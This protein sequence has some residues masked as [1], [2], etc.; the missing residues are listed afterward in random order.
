MNETT[1]ENFKIEIIGTKEYGATESVLQIA[2]K[3]KI[4]KILSSKN[5]PWRQDALALVMGGLIYPGSGEYLINL[6]KDSLLWQHCGHAKDTKPDYF[7]NYQT[8]L[9]KIAENQWI[10]EAA[11][12]KKNLKTP[13]IIFNICRIPLKK[14]SSHDNCIT[15]GLFT[16]L[17]GFP[18]SIK[19]FLEND[20][21][22]ANQGLWKNSQKNIH[23]AQ[24]K[25][26][27]VG[28]DFLLKKDFVQFDFANPISHSTSILD[29]FSDRWQAGC[30]H[31]LS[32]NQASL[33]T[34]LTIML[35]Y[36]LFRYIEKSLEKKVIVWQS[37]QDSLVNMKEIIE[38][39]KNLRSHVIKIDEK[40]MLKKINVINNQQKEI[41]LALNLKL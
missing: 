7:L 24:Q 6:Y 3:L 25:T 26:Y 33:A 19:L 30:F 38:I 35:S 11:L 21:F 34:L 36:Y 32:Y 15:F 12:C 10:I 27:L 23:G 39:L 8:P 20:P 5:Q 37:D 4:D 13:E 29:F 22:L 16:N 2:K 28:K 40:I 18:L 14:D 17:E 41:F 1:N 9:I 31:N